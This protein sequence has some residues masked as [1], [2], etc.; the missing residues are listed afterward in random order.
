MA[1]NLT[2]HW[3]LVVFLI[4]VYFLS[5]LMHLDPNIVNPGNANPITPFTISALDITGFVIALIGA[6]A[7]AALLGVILGGWAG[8]A[9]FF[10]TLLV[11]TAITNSW[12]VLLFAANVVTFGNLGLPI[13]IQFVIAA[14]C[15]II[16]A[17]T[18]LAFIS[19]VTGIGSEVKPGVA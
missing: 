16:L 1:A 10:G 7:A 11:A 13:E 3:A 18:A 19:A 4:V 8:V 15:V 17:W 5:A 12:A 9:T 14:P 2:P 6:I